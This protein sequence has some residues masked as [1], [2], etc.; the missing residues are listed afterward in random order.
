MKLNQPLTE[1]QH[2]T[3][4]EEYKALVERQ[5]KFIH[6]LADK[7]DAGG[8]LTPFEKSFATA[9]LRGAANGMSTKRKRPAGKPAQLPG[10]LAVLFAIKHVHQG[11]SKNAAYEELAAEF[12]VSVTAV[13]KELKKQ[14][15]D[16]A[17]SWIRG[18]T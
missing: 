18:E 16:E 1:E 5:K 7:L 12:S 14:N 4:D 9:V 6:S 2:K 8:Q 15:Q 3:A 13:K 17:V 11:K 10:E